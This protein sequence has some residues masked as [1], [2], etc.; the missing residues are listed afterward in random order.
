MTA[1]N[2]NSVADAA[3]D[4]LFALGDECGLRGQVAR[5]QRAGMTA[6]QAEG[7]LLAARDARQP[8]M[9]ISKGIGNWRAEQ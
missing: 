5:M 6:R 3:W 9:V 7:L 2:S 4:N 1:G 8:Y